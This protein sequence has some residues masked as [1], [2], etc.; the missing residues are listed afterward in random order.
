MGNNSKTIP[1]L[2]GP[3]FRVNA[4][5]QDAAEVNYQTQNKGSDPR[6]RHWFAAGLFQKSFGETFGAATGVSDPRLQKHP[7]KDGYEGMDSN[8]AG[9]LFQKSFGKSF[10]VATEVRE[11]LTVTRV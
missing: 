8:L 11:L 3:P 1:S 7:S 6:R 2:K 10:G 5:P 9:G 4:N